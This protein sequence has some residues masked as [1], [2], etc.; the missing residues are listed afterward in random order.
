[1]AG[2]SE[3]VDVSTKQQRIAELADKVRR[4][5]SRLWPTTSTSTGCS[6]PSTA[7][8]RTARW[9]WTDR[10]R[11]LRGEPRGQPSSRCWTAPSPARTRLR[12]CGGSISPRRARRPKPGRWGFRRSRIK[13]SS[14]R[15]SW[16]WKPIYEQD[17]LDCSYGFRPGRSAHQA[18]DEPL[19]TDDGDGGRLDRGRGHPEVLRHDG[20]RPSAGLS[21]AS[22]ARRGA[23]A[24]DRQMAQR[25]CPGGRVPH[26][27]RRRVR[28]RAG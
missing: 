3:P 13:C 6:R 5:D 18:L 11:G 19:E 12:R 14:G 2:A 7:R 23:A 21:Q 9:A 10:R 8:A 22:G 16:C 17:F 26:A 24:T 20:P 4:W 27:T 15:S 28:R 1:M 25:G